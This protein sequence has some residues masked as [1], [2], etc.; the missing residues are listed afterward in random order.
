MGMYSPKLLLLL[1]LLML[2]WNIFIDFENNRMKCCLVVDKLKCETIEGLAPYGGLLLAP[3]EGW[4]PMATSRWPLATWEAP[5]CPQ[6]GREMERCWCEGK[7]SRVLT[8]EE[9]YWSV[10]GG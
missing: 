4:W 6:N 7:V 1:L 8:E 2:L 10:G 9:T 3:A 5:L